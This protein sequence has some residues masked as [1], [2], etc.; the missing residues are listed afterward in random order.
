MTDGVLKNLKVGDIVRHVDSAH[1][2]VI[3]DDYGD[4]KIAVRTTELSNG[5]EWILIKKHTN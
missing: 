1:S 4:T 3:T 2:M 5:M